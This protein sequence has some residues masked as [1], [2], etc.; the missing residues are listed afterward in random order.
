MKKLLIL[1]LLI[2]TFSFAQAKV[3]SEGVGGGDVCENRIKVIRDDITKWITDDGARMLL[4]PNEMS[5]NFY[6]NEMLSYI[7][8]TKVRCVSNGD[9]GFPVSVE[10]VPK[11][12]RFD[13]NEKTSIITCDYNKFQAATDINQYLLIHHEYAGLADVEIPNS[14]DS[15]YSVSNQII[16][17]LVDQV[18]KKLSINTEVKNYE[19][20]NSPKTSSYAI[21]WGTQEKKINFN[22]FNNMSSEEISDYVSEK[23]MN[24]FLVNTFTKEIITTLD[25]D[26]AFYNSKGS[27]DGGGMESLSL[28]D[29][30]IE[31]PSECA[32]SVGVIEGTMYTSNLYK[33]VVEDVCS[34]EKYIFDLEKDDN[35]N[36]V[37]KEQI[38]KLLKKGNRHIFENGEHITQVIGTTIYKGQ[39]F[40]RIRYDYFIQEDIFGKSLSLEANIKFTLKNKKLSVKVISIDQMLE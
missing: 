35:L 19:I 16:S 3:G 39:R 15:D 30:L 6:S 21:A 26:F 28:N 27:V 4:L 32:T 34:D 33:I 37:I 24:N 13:K 9:I 5:S 23:K 18:I 25:I 38:G 8:I 36:A 40:N 7:K 1:L 10:G 14:S 31:G 2:A 22:I 12:C 20:L 11:V 17:F 29:I